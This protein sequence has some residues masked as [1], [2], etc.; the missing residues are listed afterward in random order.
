VESIANFDSTPDS[1]AADCSIRLVRISVISGLPK[2][3]N[4]VL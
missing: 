1:G 3:V 2:A 4:S